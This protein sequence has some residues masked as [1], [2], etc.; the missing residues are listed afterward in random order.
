MDDKRVVLILVAEILQKIQ[1]WE[2][3][4]TNGCR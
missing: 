3:Y 4:D 2:M 1:T